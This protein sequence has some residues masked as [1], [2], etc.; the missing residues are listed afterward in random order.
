MIPRDRIVQLLVETSGSSREEFAQHLD[1]PEHWAKLEKFVEAILIEPQLGIQLGHD[2]FSDN[3]QGPIDMV[4]F[5]PECGAQHIDRAEFEPTGRTVD[6]CT[7]VRYTWDNPPHKSHLC[8]NCANIWRPADVCTNGVD[9]TQ[10]RGEKDTHP[11]KSP[12]E[13][14]KRHVHVLPTKNFN[15]V[16][17]VKLTERLPSD[18]FLEVTDVTGKYICDVP[19]YMDLKPLFGDRQSLY[20]VAKF[21]NGFLTLQ[22]N[23]SPSDFK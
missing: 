10:T 23:I 20:F 13:Q 14:G 2:Q 7:E 18:E 1:N 22:D 3:P 11:F 4:L 17:K 15:P 8:H 9:T 6:N 12:Y 16:F 5:C 21:I 19:F